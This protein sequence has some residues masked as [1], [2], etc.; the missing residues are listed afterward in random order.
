MFYIKTCKYQMSY[1]L[2]LRN[3]PL[4]E[5]LEWNIFPLCPTPTP[6]G[7]GQRLANGHVYLL[8]ILWVA[9]A[10]S[11]R[12]K[13]KRVTYWVTYAR[14]YLRLL[15]NDTWTMKRR[16][17]I[18]AHSACTMLL[19]LSHNHKWMFFVNCSVSFLQCCCLYSL[20]HG[21]TYVR[22]FWIVCR[23]TYFKRSN[24]RKLLVWTN[25]IICISLICHSE[26]LLPLLL[27]LF[28]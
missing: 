22:F 13:K 21:F 27:L 6:Q 11:F 8:C 9:T 5:I 10:D 20:L 19:K 4:K 1:S 3:V 23:H 18:D 28:Q 25:I 26:Q 15:R 16:E 2:S 17:N 7:R 12:L 14:T 24:S